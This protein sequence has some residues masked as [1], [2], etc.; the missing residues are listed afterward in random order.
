MT[1]SLRLAVTADLHWG[2]SALG[3][4]A[5][6]GLRDFLAADPPDVLLLGGDVGTN[7]QFRPCLRLFADLPCRKALVPGNHDIWVQPDDPRGDSLTVYREGLAAACAAEGFHYLDAGPLILS[8][9]LAVAG[10]INWYD[11][12]WSLDLLRKRVPDWEERLRTKRLDRG[13]YMDGR[14]VRWPLDDVRFTAQVVAALGLHLNEA[15]ARSRRVVVIAHHPPLYGLTFPGDRPLTTDRLLWD[16]FTGNR[17]I[18]ELLTGHEERIPLV[19]CGHTHRARENTVGRIRGYNVGGDYH[20]KRLL[21]VNW[22][23]GAVTAHVFGD[24]E[25]R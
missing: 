24:P 23:A 6:L 19:F 25:R 18:E 4:A 12:S 15:L 11:Y 17:A 8:E 21:L 22:P 14:L 1:T 20:F 2:H 13:W 9:D 3:N 7:D 16:A 10:T 5:T